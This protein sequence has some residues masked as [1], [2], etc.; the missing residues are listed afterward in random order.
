[1]RTCPARTPLGGPS[2]G[3]HSVRGLEHAL[4]ALSQPRVALL[5]PRSKRT[6]RGIMRAILRKA[7]DDETD[8]GHSRRKSTALTAAEPGVCPWRYRAR[9]ARPVDIAGDFQRP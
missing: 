9:W 1:V 2:R 7:S 5:A 8:V 6:T 4:A 3:A